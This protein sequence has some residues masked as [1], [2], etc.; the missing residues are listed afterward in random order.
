[1]TTTILET[2]INLM[3]GKYIISLNF[4]N[5]TGYSNLVGRKYSG[6]DTAF[7]QQEK[8]HG[9]GSGAKAEAIG[10]HKKLISKYIK[11]D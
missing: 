2:E 9:K 11:K 4:N 6:S 5:D 7:F 3:Y 10:M 8:F 1:M